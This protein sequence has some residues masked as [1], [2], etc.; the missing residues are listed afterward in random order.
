M[1]QEQLMEKINKKRN[2]MINIGMSTGLHCEETIHCSQE[3]DKLLNEYN[4]LLAESKQPNPYNDTFCF[5]TPKYEQDIVNRL[6]II[7]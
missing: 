4:S 1:R 7:Y 5:P 6:Q 3:L 2:E